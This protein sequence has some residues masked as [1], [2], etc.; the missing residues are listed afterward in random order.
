MLDALE[1]KSVLTKMSH[2]H[3]L[4]YHVSLFG[5]S[6]GTGD[7]TEKLL[8]SHDLGEHYT[9]MW[10]VWVSTLNAK[11]RLNTTIARYDEELLFTATY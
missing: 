9:S 6:S 3:H 8:H 2:W 5:V 7:G 11:P 1:C 4:C 10:A